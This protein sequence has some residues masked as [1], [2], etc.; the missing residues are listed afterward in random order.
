[1]DKLDLDP[2]DVARILGFLGYGR[3]VAPV[4]FVGFEEGLGSIKTEESRK[5]L[6]ARGRFEN[7]MDLREAHLLL[8]KDGKPIDIEIQQ[9]PTQVWRYKA[10]IMLGHERAEDRSS[11]KAIKDYIGFKLGRQDTKVGNTFLTELSP[12]PARNTADASEL[13]SAFSKLDD[14]LDTRI[15]NR[16]RELKRHLMENDPP[17]VICYGTSRADDF[18]ELLDVKWNPVWPHDRDPIFQKVCTSEDSRRLLLPFFG[19]GQMRRDVV[20]RLLDHK[21]L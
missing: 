4:W 13:R 9:P 14:K 8:Q 11:G 17:M 19:Q 10:R 2:Q 20:E 3:P 1:M 6:K 18:A 15:K 5:N 7:V 21:L 16:R 12:I